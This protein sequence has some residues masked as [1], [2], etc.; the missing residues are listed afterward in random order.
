MDAL[1][2][3]TETVTARLWRETWITCVVVD[4]IAYE[5]LRVYGAAYSPDAG[6]W[7]VIEGSKGTPVVGSPVTADERHAIKSAE[8]MTIA[9]IEAAMGDSDELKLN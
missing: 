1:R 7:V 3:G 8:A 4:D 2:T 5:Q 6:G 9:A